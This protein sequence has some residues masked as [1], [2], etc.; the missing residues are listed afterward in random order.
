VVGYGQFCPVAKSSEL[1]CEKWVPL[2]VMQ[3]M[4]GSTRYNDIHRGVPLISPALLS[5]RLRRLEATGVIDRQR[6]GRGSEYTL[7]EAGWELYPIIE[8]MGVWGQR[9]ARSRYTADEL[10]PSLLM[11]DMRRMLQPVGLAAKRTVVEFRFSGAP[12]GKSAYWLVV[13]SAVETGID[14]CLVDPGHPVDLRVR[15]DLRGLIQVWMGD[16]TM[17]DAMKSGAVTL[18]GPRSLVKRFP[19]WLAQHPILGKVRHARI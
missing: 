18:D 15:A 17:S 14:L 13:D 19:D 5:K 12:A 10:D 1:L 2:I 11:W 3:L 6:I 8:A 16:Q 7:T 4:L 9:W